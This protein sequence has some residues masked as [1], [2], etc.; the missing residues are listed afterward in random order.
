MKHPTT[1]SCHWCNS[2][3][4]Y[5]ARYC[6]H[7]GSAVPDVSM[8][9]TLPPEHEDRVAPIIKKLGSAASLVYSKPKP[10][11]KKNDSAVRYSLIMKGTTP[12]DQVRR[13]Y[14]HYARVNDIET[15]EKEAAKVVD[16]IKDDRLPEHDFYKL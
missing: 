10:Y 6:P 13:V 12:A 15:A 3:N 14:W 5:G 8:G 7:C 11:A 16:D 2:P 4:C 9:S 1:A